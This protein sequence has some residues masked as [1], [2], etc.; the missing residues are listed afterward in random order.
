MKNK[1][2]PPQR[3]HPVGHSAGCRDL[4]L[5][6]PHTL[7]GLSP[8]LLLGKEAGSAM[9]VY[10][11]LKTTKKPVNIIGISLVFLWLRL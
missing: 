4:F 7:V 8:G 5:S 10:H 9:V 3:A 6:Y 11:I 2:K 1:T